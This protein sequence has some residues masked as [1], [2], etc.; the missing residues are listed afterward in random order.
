MPRI[1]TKNRPTPV[2]LLGIE[3]SISDQ[4]GGILRK[5]KQPFRIAPFAQ[6][7]EILRKSDS[8]VHQLIFCG[9]ESKE[10]LGFLHSIKDREEGL[11]V[12]VVTRTFDLGHWLDLL[13][14]GAADYCLVPLEEEHIQWILGKVRQTVS[15]LVT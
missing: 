5:Q 14:A 2:L 3:E 11:S 9:A 1:K 15:E 13:E 12:V 4:L 7:A 8:Q 6:A 10:A